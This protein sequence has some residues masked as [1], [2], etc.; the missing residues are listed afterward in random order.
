MAEYGAHLTSAGVED[1]GRPS[2]FEVLAQESLMSTLRPA[3]K[4]I[5]RVSCK[6]RPIHS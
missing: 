3:L 1:G 2:F 5:I 6:I 4:H